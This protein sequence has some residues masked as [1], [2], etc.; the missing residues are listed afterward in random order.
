MQVD[1]SQ[2]ISR[3]R[4]SAGWREMGAVKACKESKLAKY[5][6]EFNPEVDSLPSS[7]APVS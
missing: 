6:L 7:S 4:A 2:M 5:V 3:K 1:R